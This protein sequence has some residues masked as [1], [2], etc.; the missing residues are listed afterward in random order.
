[1]LL[2]ENDKKILRVL[3]RDGK[4]SLQA[5]ADEVNMSTSPCW[6]RIKRLEEAG[7][8]DRYAAILNPRLLGLHAQAYM[9]VSLLDHTEAT[10]E[11]FDR[12]VQTED[13]ITECC[14]ITG[15][16]DYMLKV[17][18]EGPEELETFIMKRVLRLGIVR[19]SHTNFVLRRTKSSTALPV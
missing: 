17:V 5:L 3:Q 6:R 19:S 8:I 15:S 12:F 7:L 2:E 14:S 18:A 13:Q 9:H 16:N 10:I 11:A 4:I 1:M